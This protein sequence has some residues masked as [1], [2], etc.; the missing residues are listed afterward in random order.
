MPDLPVILVVEDD[1]QVRI[2]IAQFLEDCGYRLALANDHDIGAQIMQALRPNLLIADVRLRGGN[3]H[4]LAKLAHAMAIP[5]I[6]ISGEPIAVN[7]HQGGAVPFIQKPFRLSELQATIRKL[8][9]E[10]RL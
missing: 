6:L 7:L 5:A 2:L 10:R 8:L 4:D 3:G 1:Y 9:Q